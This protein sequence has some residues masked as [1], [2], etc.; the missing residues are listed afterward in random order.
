VHQLANKSFDN[1]T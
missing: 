1:P